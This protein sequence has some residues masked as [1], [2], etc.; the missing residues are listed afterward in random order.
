MVEDKLNTFFIV[1]VVI[2][3]Y[4]CKNVI[5]RAVK[6][7][8][9]QTY[10][11]MELILVDDCSTDG[12]LE[13]LYK[14]RVNYGSDWM[15]IIERK[16]NCGP[17]GTRNDGWEVATQPYIAF[18]DADDS[19]HPRKIEIQLNFMLKHPDIVLSAHKYRVIPSNIE[20][21]H[22]PSSMPKI[23]IFKKNQLLFHN[24]ISTPTVMLKKN[25]PFRFPVKRYSE[26]YLLWLL[27]SE[28]YKCV[29]LEEE[30]AYCYKKA[31]RESGLSAKLWKMEKGEL[32]N[33]VFLLLSKRIN[34]LLFVLSF[35]YSFVKFMRRIIIS[36][37][38]K[39]GKNVS[40]S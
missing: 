2:P 25:I 4:N 26:D 17:G 3:C 6:S 33:Y 22:E 18:L 20:H 31:Y 34:I 13:L 7:V 19:W 14:I 32:D 1:S 38:Y 27:L 15:K 9:I 30:L 36:Y 8:Y 24:F 16:E 23:K 35:L 40:K 28:G 10:R 39:R 37:L 11:P 12:T 5:E 29:F 21:F